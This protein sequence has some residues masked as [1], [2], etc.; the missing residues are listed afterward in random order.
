MQAQSQGLT[1][2]DPLPSSGWVPQD[3]TELPQARQALED[4]AGLW[5]AMIESRYVIKVLI[6]PDDG[7]IVDA[8]QAAA[9]FYGYPREVLKQRHAWDQNADM[10]REA[11]LA[12]FADFKTGRANRGT[13]FLARHRRANGEICEV[14]V[15]LDLIHRDHR[16]LLLATVLDIT[17]RKAAE[18]ALQRSE[19]RFRTLF[20]AAKV[21]MLLIDSTTGAIVDANAAAAA[22]YGF[23]LGQLRGMAIGALNT[24]SATEITAQ[25]HQAAA[26][27]RWL[28]HFRHRLADGTLRDVEVHSGPLELDGRP[29]LYSIV[30]DITDKKAAEDALRASEERLQLVLEGSSDGFWD[31]NVRT[32]EILFSRRWAEM[33]GYDQTEVQPHIRIWKQLMHPDDQQRSRAALHAHFA[34]DTARYQVEHRIRT[35]QGEWRWF[36]HRGKVMAR[37][38]RGRPVRMAGTHTDITE[39]RRI[40]TALRVSLVA[41]ERHDAQM[42][43]LNRMNERLL[44]CETRAAAYAAIARSAG[45]L[46][47]GFSGALA[48]FGEDA[49][50]DLQVV[51]DWGDLSIL[52][53]TFP[54]GHCWALR[55]GEV[56]EV[57][58]PT[59]GSHCGH[60]ADPLPFPSLCIPLTVR[61]ETLGLLHVGARQT[62]TEGQF[63]DLRTLAIAVSEA[64]RLA[65]SNIRLQETLR[66][67]A[68]RDPLTG[69]FNRRYLDETLPREL[70]VS[71]RRGEPLA[72]AMLDLDHFKRFNDA[73]GHEAG[74]AVL[75][76]VGALLN[77][78]LRAGDL[79]CRYGGEELTLILPGTSLDAARE[80]LDGLR[81]AIMQTRILY[82]GGD[83]PAITASVGVAVAGGEET[84]ATALLARADAALYRAKEAGRNRIVADEVPVG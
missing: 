2:A 67:Q 48:V 12:L 20:A 65:L 78:S 74:D 59:R 22:Y 52:P 32:G 7:H 60:F 73:Y 42:V 46:F 51:A 58:D 38:A 35:K 47:A 44:S 56:H 21:V 55:R 83:L 25:I 54:R 27:Q 64:A 57:M 70:Q 29:L 71:R 66:E 79:A 24:L 30:H 61:G 17:E 39:R 45:E 36:L 33:L 9:E 1:P 16:S 76:A 34:G 11:L 14:A 80:R 41:A 50:A 31:W 63:A 4:A 18:T 69:L 68:I 8:N 77:A 62:L 15:H 13:E 84:D 28:F 53:T 3:A 43:A 26:G 6:D 40:E 81:R 49:G 72:V 82:R 75:R 5:R 23:T 37:D 19:M 10:P